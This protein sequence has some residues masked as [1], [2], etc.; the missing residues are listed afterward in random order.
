ML[1]D[2]AANTSLANQTFNIG[3]TTVTWTAKDAVGNHSECSFKVIV[4]S[5]LT[6]AANSH[7]WDYDGENHTDPD[8][9]VTT[10]THTSNISG[11]SGTALTLPNGDQLTATITGTAHNVG[12]VANVV[13]DVTIMRGE[14]D[15]T[16]YYNIV[17]NNGV[18]TIKPIVIESAPEY[19][20]SGTTYTAEFDAS[21][22]GNNGTI[23]YAWSDATGEYTGNDDISV[24]LTN[25]QT[26]NQTVVFTVTPT[27]T[28]TDGN[29]TIVGPE[30]EISVIVWP[31]L[32]VN[33]ITGGGTYCLG[34]TVTLTETPQYGSGS[35]NI[36]WK[37]GET[38][39]QTDNGVTT[40]SYTPSTA[41]SG[42]SETA[43]PKKGSR[44]SKGMCVACALCMAKSSA[45][46]RS[47]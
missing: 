25:T 31:A 30:K 9:V 19:I 20:C 2:D 10:T 38:T 14:E 13:G 12:T 18:L 26:T 16:Q 40:S 47:Q 6:I 37:N 39:L 35:Y 46:R 44:F 7:G 42:S 1:A 15:V 4:K 34:A 23:T 8:F 17:K 32:V 28:S 29:T 5:G 43:L 45:P 3:E 33:N 11:T 21:I 41:T 24:A 27:F 36:V 22:A